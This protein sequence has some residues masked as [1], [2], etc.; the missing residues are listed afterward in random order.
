MVAVSFNT[1]EAVWRC[2]LDELPT[3]EVLKV[4]VRESMDSCSVNVSRTVSVTVAM[5][6]AEL[7]RVA[8]GEVELDKLVETVIEELF[9]MDIVA[10][11]DIFG[12][13]AVKVVRP[14]AVEKRVRVDV[15]F[16]DLVG[17]CFIVS[18]N[19]S[20]GDAVNINV[21]VAIVLYVWSKVLENV[22][23]ED[24]ERL[25]PRVTLI[26]SCPVTVS[27]PEMDGVIDKLLLSDAL[28]T[29]LNVVVAVRVSF[30]LYDMVTVPAGVS[31]SEIV[32]ERSRECSS[33]G[34][35]F[36][37]DADSESVEL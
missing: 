1:I 34:V 13:E 37:R 9:S 12:I 17:E 4:K 29:L 3:G 35:F 28:P 26:V 7:S 32:R 6:V 11:A 23:E 25:S 21:W 16:K 14:D 5:G 31:V 27:F 36:E 18:E 19:V 33:V 2:V 22:P 20:T 24:V 10:V 8:V 30:L 15:A